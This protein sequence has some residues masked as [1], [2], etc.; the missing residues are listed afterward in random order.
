MNTDD[1]KAGLTRGSPGTQDAMLGAALVQK[2]VAG[3]WGLVPGY[4]I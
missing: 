2:A 1:K 4:R 3:I